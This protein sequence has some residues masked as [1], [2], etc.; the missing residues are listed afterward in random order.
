MQTTIERI[1]SNVRGYARLFPTV[2]QSAVGSTLTDTAGKTYIDFFCGAGSL[3]YGHNPRKAKAALLDY[4]ERD[5]VQHSLDTATVAKVDFLDTF[6]RLILRPRGLQYRIQFTG[7]TGTNAVE[8]AIK[9]ARKQTGRSHVIAFTGGYHG[10]SLGSLALTANQYYHSESYGSHNNVTH[11]P[12]DG[13]LDDQDTSEILAKMLQDRSSGLPM[14]AAVILET[15]QGEGGIN[16]ASDAWL[17]RI[18]SICEEHDIRLIID[19]IQVGNG[20]TG[21]FFSFERAGITPDLVCL[22]KSIGGGLPMSLLLIRPERDTWNPGEHTG[23]FRGNNLAFVAATAVLRHWA[24]PKFETEI[25]VRSE[26]VRQRM[27]QICHRHRDAGFECR[28]RG[29]IWGIDV[30]RGDLASE[31]IRRAFKAGLLIEASGNKDQV[32]KVM[33]ALTIPM[34]LLDQGLKILDSSIRQTMASIPTVSEKPAS[35]AVVFP[36]LAMPTGASSLQGSN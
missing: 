21:T 8:A 20:R 30:K 31:V 33:P 24:D 23:T 28:G 11:L 5:G 1:E 7:P 2:F 35:T 29:L 27:E 14:P 12:F 18:A 4:I 25:A 19:D 22:S 15:V 10:H 16:V 36:N 17:R 32:L 13:Y 34:A 9:L 3:N 6:D 26:R